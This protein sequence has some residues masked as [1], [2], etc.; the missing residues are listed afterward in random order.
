MKEYTMTMLESAWI[1][2]ILRV[3]FQLEEVSN[4]SFLIHRGSPSPLPWVYSRLTVQQL[5]V[6]SC[7]STLC[8]ILRW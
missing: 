6:D 3:L 1:P 5:A 4:P 7:S 2:E 8:C